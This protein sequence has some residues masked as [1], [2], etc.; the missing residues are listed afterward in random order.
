M[1]S[2]AR[3]CVAVPPTF[4]W[5]HSNFSY[6]AEHHL[7]PAMNSDYY[8]LVS[9]LLREHFGEHYHRLTIGSAWTALLGSEVA[10]KRRDPATTPSVPPVL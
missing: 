5:L 7:F 10:A 2:P 8:P 3:A 9:D 1:C 4:N 6:H